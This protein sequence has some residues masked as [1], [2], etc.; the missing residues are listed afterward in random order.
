MTRIYLSATVPLLRE[1]SETSKLPVSRAH[2]VTP[3]LREWY[4]EGELED[5]EY[6]AFTRAAQDALWLLA[7][8]PS[9]PPRRV[10]VSVDLPD[11]Q[12]SVPVGELGDSRVTVAAA[13]P[14][15]A[16]AAIHVDGPEAATDVTTAR[17][18]VTAASAG[19][20]DAEFIVES[21][22]DRELEWYDP[23][24]LARL[25]ETL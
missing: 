9:A 12:F 23:S 16:V 18:L 20:A 24:E 3:G 8:D 19:D 22:E 21:V 2:A 15:R 4:I 14:L 11:D 13:V 1:L 25:L 6:A 7:D 17:G 5:L 10:V